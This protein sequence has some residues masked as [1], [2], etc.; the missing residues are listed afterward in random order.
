M[1]GKGDYDQLFPH[2]KPPQLHYQLRNLDEA[3][4]AIKEGLLLDDGNVSLH[5]LMKRIKE[6]EKEAEAKQ[7]EYYDAGV[8]P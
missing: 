5:A 3:K 6:A 4:T 2:I 7:R 1:C 8:F